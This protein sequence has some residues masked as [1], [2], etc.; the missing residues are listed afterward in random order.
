M[1]VLNKNDPK[2]DPWGT[3]CEI[4]CRELYE[5]AI[6]VLCLRCLK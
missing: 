1:W 6:L 3:L 2:I 4:S 5:S